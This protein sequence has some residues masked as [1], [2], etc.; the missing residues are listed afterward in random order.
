MREL[1]EHTEG[2]HTNTFKKLNEPKKSRGLTRR[3]HSQLTTKDQGDNRLKVP[4]LNS[5]GSQVI[6]KI[7]NTNEKRKFTRNSSREGTVSSMSIDF[8]KMD[9]GRDEQYSDY[10]KMVSAG[11]QQNRLED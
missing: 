2:S 10:S 1:N 9:K 6:P 4:K 5:K 3:K 8:D 11:Q 7:A